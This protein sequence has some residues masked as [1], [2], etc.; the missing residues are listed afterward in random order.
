VSKTIHHC[1][2]VCED[3]IAVRD[4]SEMGCSSSSPQKNTSPIPL[5]QSPSCPSPI[6]SSLIFPFSTPIPEINPS[7]YRIS[8]Y[9]AAGGVGVVYSAIHHYSGEKIAMKFF[10]YSTKS[11]NRKD[12][13]REIELFA[14]VNN[15]RGIVQLKGVFLD[16]PNGYVNNKQTKECYPV[17]CM[18]LLEGGDLF[19]RI[20]ARK[21]VSEKFVAKIFLEIL[22]ALDALHQIGY[23]HCDLKLENVMFT[24]NQENTEVKLIDFGLM[25]KLPS[26]GIFLCETIHGTAGYVAPESIKYCQYSTKS[27]IW[28]AGCILYSLLSGFQAFHPQYPELIVQGKFMKMSG[29]GWDNISIEAKDLMKHIFH[30]NPEER[31]SITQILSHPWLQ[32]S[33]ATPDIDLGEEYYQRIK[34]RALRQRMKNIVFNRDALVMNLEIKEKLK[35]ILPIL[36]PRQKQRRTRSSVIR[37]LPS[38][39]GGG[40]GGGSGGPVGGGGGL[41]DLSLL[42]SSRDDSTPSQPSHLLHPSSSSSH[43]SS[44]RSPYRHVVSLDDIDLL[45]RQRTQRKNCAE[46]IEHEIHKKVI[47]DFNVKLTTLRTTLVQQT[48]G[49]A[50]YRSA[51]TRDQRKNSDASSTDQ[52]APLPEIDLETFISVLHDCDLPEL[53]TPQMFHIFGLFF[54]PPS[55]LPSLLSLLTPHSCPPPP[56][57]PAIDPKSTGKID[58][59]EFLITMV[60]FHDTANDTM[61]DR[62]PQPHDLFSA[63][64]PSFDFQNFSPSPD[65]RHH[66]SDNGNDPPST[67]LGGL[68]APSRGKIV[69]ESEGGRGGEGGGGDGERNR[70]KQEDQ[71][72]EDE[73]DEDDEHIRFYFNMFDFDHTGKIELDEMKIVIRCIFADLVNNQQQSSSSPSSSALPTPRRSSSSQQY[74][75]LTSVPTLSDIEMMFENILQHSNINSKKNSIDYQEFKL[76]YRNLFLASSSI[77]HKNHKSNKQPKSSKAAE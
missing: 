11:V 14:T 31:Y 60:A 57:L 38:M 53:A 77:V 55:L 69:D 34:Q 33:D 9:I 73:E 35:R 1:S 28:Q 40:G 59:K 66:S 17:I 20:Q 68:V 67:G 21:I 56:F 36:K 15:L 74:P 47:D 75:P 30:I 12:I 43:D 49:G 51:A 72:W 27:D 16:T 3:S 2:V 52:E 22:L 46:T 58:I 6:S 70:G 18:E 41:E 7:D 23:I 62:P 50:R 25:V 10:G 32:D 8:H 37:A 19:D 48:V 24:S 39:P 5:S 45:Y 63:D 61:A 4:W 71:D 44:S 54:P 42:S 64:E 29:I 13:F 76:F 26:N 65:S